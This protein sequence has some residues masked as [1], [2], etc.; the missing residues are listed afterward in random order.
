MSGLVIQRA[1][2]VKNW[3]RFCEKLR[4]ICEL[5]QLP[6]ARNRTAA[7]G[8][9]YAWEFDRLRIIE[10]KKIR[11]CGEESDLND[12]NWS[13]FGADFLDHNREITSCAGI[14]AVSQKLL[15]LGEAFQC[16]FDRALPG[17]NLIG[18]NPVSL[19]W[20]GFAESGFAFSMSFRFSRKRH[21]LK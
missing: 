10:A 6:S 9:A 1:G 12:R 21:R 2:F 15:R 11:F 20:A 4:P 17:L 7:S 8:C 18:E 5:K 13:R 3:G 19:S 14:P 16:Q